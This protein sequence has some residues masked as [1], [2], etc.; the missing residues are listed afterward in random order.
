MTGRSGNCWKQRCRCLR[1][2]PRLVKAREGDERV[3]GVVNAMSVDV[4]DYYQVSAFAGT[5]DRAK[6]DSFPS[7]VE[8]SDEADPGSFRRSGHTRDVLHAGMR[9]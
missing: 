2:I 7:R 6:W 1:S 5:V 4:E 8:D 3:N 9:R